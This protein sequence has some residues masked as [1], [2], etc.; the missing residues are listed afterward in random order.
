MVTG[1]PEKTCHYW[2][3]VAQQLR[4]ALRCLRRGIALHTFG[5]YLRQGINMGI[6]TDTYPHH[7]LE[8]MRSVSYYARIIGETVADLE[9]VMCL[10]PRLWVA[11]AWDAMTS[12]A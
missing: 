4:I 5:G 7:F 3:S 10:T 9:R 2:P 6:G 8:E 11:R 1:L 12:A